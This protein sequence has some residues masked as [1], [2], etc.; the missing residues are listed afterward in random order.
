MGRQCHYTHLQFY[1]IPILC[2]PTIS[3]TLSNHTQNL[4]TIKQHFCTPSSSTPTDPN[5]ISSLFCFQIGLFYMSEKQHNTVILI[6]QVWL[7]SLSLSSR[8]ICI[9][10]FINSLFLQKAESYSIVIINHPLLIISYTKRLTQWPSPLC[11]N[12]Y[13]MRNMTVRKVQVSILIFC[14]CTIKWEIAGS[15]GDYTCIWLL[16]LFPQ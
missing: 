2:I 3:R 11:D 9:A 6:S 8:S 1:A 15:L 10:S 14:A 7:I 13:C 5:T 4:W 16:I 12:A